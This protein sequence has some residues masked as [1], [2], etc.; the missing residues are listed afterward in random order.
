[1]SGFP[2][3]RFL[4]DNI[5]IVLVQGIRGT[6]VRS[7][8]FF[9]SALFLGQRKGILQEHLIVSLVACQIIKGEGK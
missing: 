3:M 4:N 9:E 2:K 5:I 1:L 6:E 7:L 8:R